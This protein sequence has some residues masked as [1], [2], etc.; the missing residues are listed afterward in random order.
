MFGLGFERSA[1]GMLIDLASTIPTIA[2]VSSKVRDYSVVLL[3]APNVDGEATY[4]LKLTPLRAPKQNRIRELW[5]D[6]ATYF[7]RRAVLAGNFTMAPLVDVPWAIDFVRFEG[8]LFIVC[9][10]SA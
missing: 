4:H 8:A 9:A 10:H 3:D 7:P 5:I 6:A 1:N 2:V